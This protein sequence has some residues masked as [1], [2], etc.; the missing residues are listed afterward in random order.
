[1]LRHFAAQNFSLHHGIDEKVTTLD[2]NICLIIV[3]NLTM[4]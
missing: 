3:A 4:K 1:M 2:E